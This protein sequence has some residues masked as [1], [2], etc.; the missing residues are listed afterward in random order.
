LDFRGLGALRA[1]RTLRKLDTSGFEAPWL[2]QNIEKTP[3]FWLRG[4]LARPEHRENSSL[5]TSKPLGLRKLGSRSPRGHFEVT[6]RSLGS[7]KLASKSLRGHFEVTWLDK[8]RLKVTSRSRN[9]KKTRLEVTS[10]SSK[11][12]KNLRLLASRP[13]GSRKLGSMSL[14]GHLA[15]RNS[16]RSRFK[17]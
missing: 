15:R 9:L 4:H 14:R 6:S 8:T 16:A 11:L 12:D 3:D 2:A 10:R 1:F 17:V 5:L 13:L 7:R